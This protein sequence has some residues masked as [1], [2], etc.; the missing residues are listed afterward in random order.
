MRLAGEEG[1]LTIKSQSEGAARE[2]FEYE[3]PREDAQR[4]LDKI[5]LKPLIEKTRYE[6]FHA[7]HKWEI[8]EFHGVNEGL[9]IAEVELEDPAE[10]I[11]KPDWI[12]KEV[13][14][15]ARYFNLNLVKQ[16]YSL[17]TAVETR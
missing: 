6:V 5:W 8:D 14:G 7:G 2:E 15:D 3:I 11:R 16:P 9:V 1:A 13:T 17:W 10:E 12:G 4:M